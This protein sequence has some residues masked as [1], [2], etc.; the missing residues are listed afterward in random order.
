M[1][2]DLRTC[3][4]A[5][6][7]FDKTT[8][9][10]LLDNVLSGVNFAVFVV[11]E[12]QKVFWANR[13]FCAFTGLEPDAFLGRSIGFFDAAETTPSISDCVARTRDL[14]RSTACGVTM[15]AVDQCECK[16]DVDV[17][18]ITDRVGRTFS[19]AT[20]VKA[21]DLEQSRES[22]E[23]AFAHEII[24]R[25][26][27]GILAIDETGSIVFCNAAAATLF[28]RVNTDMIGTPFG[29]PFS[30]GSDWTSLEVA[31]KGEPV[32]LD[33]RTTPVSWQGQDATLVT[34]RD[35]TQRY[36]AETIAAM[37]LEAMD[38][39]ANGIFVTDTTGLIKWVNRAISRISGYSEDELI[40]NEPSVLRSDAHE[41]QFYKEMWDTI[42]SGRT[43]QGQ[44]VNR[45]K[46]G[47]LYTAEQSVTPINDNAGRLT[48]Y[49]AI[50]EDITD[51]LK[52]Q[53][54]LVH[55][56]G[57]DSLTDL[58]NRN[59]FMRRVDAALDRAARASRRVAVMVMDLDHFKDVNNTLGHDVGDQLIVTVTER[60][61]CL[62]RNTDTMSRL[63]GDEFGI[64]LEDLE[65]TNA[66]SRMVRRILETFDVPIEIAER[67]V[68]MT[69]SIGISVYPE[70]N[71]DSL[72]LLRH[73]ELAMYRV[74]S[75]GGQAFQY[76]D[77]AMDDEIRARV[78]LERDLREAIKN[79]ELWLAYQAQVNLESGAVIGAE[80]LLRWN[81]PTHG[82]VPPDEFIPVAE[83]S[84]LILPIGDWI[85][86]EIC[87]QTALWRSEGMA[88]IQIGINVSGHQFEHREL[89]AQV[90]DQLSQCG[91]DIDA[92]DLEITETVAMERTERVTRNVDQLVDAG[93]SISMDDFGT[94]Y[95]SLS[96]LLA[97]PVR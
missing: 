11:D 91:L 29:F 75:D 61:Q 51:R 54:D 33:M 72:N 23:T 81:H 5:T 2:T 16:V 85:I 64:L 52:A 9:L 69:A 19:V 60:V 28:G 70:D 74:K 80:A 82:L 56:A 25:A 89:G 46:D 41:P 66:A 53:T 58:P 63:G 15:Q 17:S 32:Y 92:V 35:V 22:Q 40:K 57:F 84:G 26:S 77:Q 93:V 47:Q 8:G 79:N 96:N 1:N 88:P 20:L 68:K 71:V 27:D 14:G 78:S 48:H 30:K 62:M 10:A 36:E 34:L 49:V 3:E 39:S 6:L 67:A 55:L 65:D 90:L 45:H 44:I 24:A 31:V 42:R 18:I 37:H 95:S 38:A 83:A 13:A 12:A 43:W 87:C 76:F 50:Q 59:L 4:P 73:A 21:S 7:A 97:F 86:E 94:G